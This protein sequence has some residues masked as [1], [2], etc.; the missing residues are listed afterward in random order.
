[1]NRK[2]LVDSAL[3]IGKHANDLAAMLNDGS[4]PD[5]ELPNLAPRLKALS[6]AFYQL[7]MRAGAERW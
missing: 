4:F 7:R 2:D 3:A 1:M 5:T 6:M